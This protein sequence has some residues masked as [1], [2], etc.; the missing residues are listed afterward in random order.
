MSRY[1]FYIPDEKRDP[2][3]GIMNIVRHCSLARRLGAQ[4]VLAT[5]SGRDSHGRYWF[6]HGMDYIK[7]SERR[8]DDICVIPDFFTDLVA[9]VTG[10]CI[11]YMQSP[12]WLKQNFDYTRPD[13]TIWT[14]SPM[15]LE[16]CRALYPGK[17]IPI[18]PNIVDS[19]A[20]PFIPQAERKD[21]MII[22]FP[23]KGADFI[24]KVFAEYRQMGGRFWKPLVVDKMPFEKMIL[25][26][27]RAQAFL[28]S[29]EAE[30]CA[31]PPQES[32]AAGVV[33][34][35]RNACGANFCMQ[36]GKTAMVCDYA[37]GAATFLLTLENPAIR[38]EL[39]KRAYEY[40]KRSFADA[41]PTRF[42]RTI[43]AREVW[44]TDVS[45]LVAV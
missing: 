41:E 10:P 27:R 36:H 22:V 18:V 9:S 2:T 11:V 3:G 42:W 40:I 14:D 26:F 6:K 23:R 38:T 35:G 5:E 24:T 17:D 31:L 29:A 19:E 1:V 12:L 16:R 8:P 21:G 34:V 39:A 30:G 45:S 33:V 44:H 13:L 25:L 15:M 28:A 43:L 4:A 37:E 20:F 32:M 7:W